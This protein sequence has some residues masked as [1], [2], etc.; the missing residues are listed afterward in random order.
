MGMTT[1]NKGKSNSKS[2]CRSFDFVPAGHFAQDDIVV[3]IWSMSRRS[4]CNSRFPSGMTERK[5][6]A[7]TGG[8]LLLPPKPQA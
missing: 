8:H 6:R 5:A 7:T 3:F 4:K 1:K 2:N